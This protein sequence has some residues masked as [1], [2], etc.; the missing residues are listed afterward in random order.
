MRSR[1]KKRYAVIAVV[2]AA[3]IA[4][5]IALTAAG[6]SIAS[7]QKYNFAY[8]RWQGEGKESYSQ[9]SC[10][11][12]DDSG[13]TTDSLSSVR[14]Q[15]MSELK[16]IS[17]TAEEGQKLCPDA[18]SA[19]VGS[20][21]VRCDIAGRTEA[22]LTAV[23][24]DFFLFRDF[25]LVDGAFFTDNDIMQDGAVIDRELAWALYGSDNVSGMNIYI[26]G[27]KC[28]IS[29]VITAPETEYEQKC[30][31]KAPQAYISYDMADSLSQE[32]DIGYIEGTGFNK[33]ACYECIVPDPVENFGEN[34]LTEILGTGFDGKVSIVRN[35]GRFTPSKR[36]KELKKLTGY[37]VRDD[38]I[39]LPWWENAS[40]MTE[41]RLTYLYSVRRLLIAL[42]VLTLLWLAFLAAKAYKKKKPLIKR[43]ISDLWEKLRLSLS[44]KLRKNENTSDS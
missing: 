43:K 6:S 11:F 9:I 13:F 33:I 23:G 26:N 3:A 35:D 31:G 25:T 38:G 18:Y 5:A 24:G 42:P 17:V 28:Y 22:Q 19:P 10:F 37:A 29:G 16:N 2:N 14:G 36:A 7:A 20:A 34:K 8:E 27:I 40:R 44:D 12:A 15:L 41:F 4:G 1:I 39:K 30:A 32:A 21:V